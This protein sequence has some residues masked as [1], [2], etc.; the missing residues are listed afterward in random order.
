VFILSRAASVIPITDVRSEPPEPDVVVTPGQ[1][2]IELLDWHQDF[3][4]GNW[5]K[6]HRS[7][8]RSPVMGHDGLFRTWL[9]YKSFVNWNAA[10]FMGGN[11]SR[12][13]KLL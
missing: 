6:V 1:L 2:F 10:T 13:L 12:V 11:R 4:V 3:S 9:Q 5:F 7:I 8:L